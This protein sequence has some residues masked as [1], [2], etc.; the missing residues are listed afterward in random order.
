MERGGP[1]CVGAGDVG[2]CA[3][4][5]G[6]TATGACVAVIGDAHAARMTT[7]GKKRTG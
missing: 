7:K 2:T 3:T 5:E 1:A 6:D 4:G